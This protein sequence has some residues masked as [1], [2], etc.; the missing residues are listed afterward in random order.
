[1]LILSL[2]VICFAGDGYGDVSQPS[3]LFTFC[4]IYPPGP[5][6]SLTFLVGSCDPDGVRSLVWLLI[7]P[8]KVSFW[9]LRTVSRVLFRGFD[10]E[11][12]WPNPGLRWTALSA[13]LTPIVSG[14]LML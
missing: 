9:H 5:S 11:T 2:L 6:P 13:S 8:S 7:Q 3:L 1:M 12:L 14:R 10:A 4:F